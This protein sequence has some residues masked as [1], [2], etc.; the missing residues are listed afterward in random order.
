[1]IDQCHACNRSS[2]DHLQLPSDA[3]ARRKLQSQAAQ[4]SRQ[5]SDLLWRMPRPLLLLLKTNDCLRTVDACLGQVD[6]HWFSLQ[7]DGR[8][9][10]LLCLALAEGVIFLWL[11]VPTYLDAPHPSEKEKCSKRFAVASGADVE[12]RGIYFCAVQA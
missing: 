10:A 6:L 8:C 7:A 12:C 9:G 11:A 4:F 2:L 3:E 5:I 1:M